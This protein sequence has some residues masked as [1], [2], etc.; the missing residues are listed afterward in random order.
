MKVGNFH[1]ITTIIGKKERNKM[2][3]DKAD[4][5]LD[6]VTEKKLQEYYF[7]FK[8]MERL[9]KKYNLLFISPHTV[10]VSYP[11]SGR[12]WLR[13][14][15]AKL[16]QLSLGEKAKSDKYEIFPAIH[17]TY[18][19]FK[20]RFK[21][22][23]Y[24]KLNVIFLHRH[25]GDVAVSRFLE[26]K[27]S[28]RDEVGFEGSIDQYIRRDQD[29]GI[30]KIIEY[31]NKW[32]E[33]GGNFNTFLVLLYYMLHKEP[34]ACLYAISKMIGLPVTKE[35]IEEAIEFGH[36]NNMKK[37]EKNDDENEN[38]LKHY[39]GN[40]GAS[41]KYDRVNIGKYNNYINILKKEDVDYI[42][43]CMKE[44]NIDYAYDEDEEK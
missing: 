20:E 40:F 37:I 22:N 33:K 23:D 42:H 11:K 2:S 6:F 41:G 28:H 36:F 29:Y 30:T 38:L 35:Q 1:I 27:H 15:M 13:M 21:E 19:D 7:E 14:M 17:D 10:L 34:F 18:K 32:I 39:K 12:T 26:M 24:K 25:P 8:E 5:N 31:N 3:K 44:S 4:S 43:E 9:Q 16:M